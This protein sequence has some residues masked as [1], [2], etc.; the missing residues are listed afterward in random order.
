MNRSAERRRPDRGSRSG[1]AVK[2]DTT[3]PLCGEECPGVMRR[4]IR[5]VKR[6]AVKIDVKIAVRKASEIGLALAEADSVA[7]QRKRP[8]NNLHDLAVISNRRR[9]ILNVSIGDKRLG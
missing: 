4:R 5:V 8:R 7:A 6:Y 9:E 3:D 1:A 2:I